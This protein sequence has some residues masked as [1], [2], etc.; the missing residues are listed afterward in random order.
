MMRSAFLLAVGSLLLLTLVGS[1]NG[2]VA[3]LA[4]TVTA[5]SLHKALYVRGGAAFKNKPINPYK[6]NKVASASAASGHHEEDLMSAP[7]AIAN[8]LADLCPHGMLPIGT[9][10]CTVIPSS[11]WVDLGLVCSVWFVEF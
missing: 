7:T 1:A 5:P 6:P 10:I 8:V 2:E 11:Y 3:T 4:S 9:Y